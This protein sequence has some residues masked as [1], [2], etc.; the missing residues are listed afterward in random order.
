M[1]PA[2]GARGEPAQHGVG[3]F[4]VEAEPVDHALVGMEPEQ[5]RARIAGLRQRRHRADL[6]E[7]EAEPQQRVGHL[8]M[9]VEARRHAD[10]IGEIEAEGT[11]R[12]PRIVRRRPRKRRELAAH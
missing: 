5:A 6:D 12:E 8:G 2:F 7:A 9:L 11:H 3:A 4:A 1:P 10:R